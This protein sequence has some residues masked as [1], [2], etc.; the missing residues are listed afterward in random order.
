MWVGRYRI[1]QTVYIQSV[2]YLS[3]KVGAFGDR[4]VDESRDMVEG[5]VLLGLD[6]VK[7]PTSNLCHAA[8][9]RFLKQLTRFECIV[10]YLYAVGTTYWAIHNKI[11]N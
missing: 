10:V 2:K 3:H 5:P 9:T 1:D 6:L 11:N 4:K 8:I 7:H